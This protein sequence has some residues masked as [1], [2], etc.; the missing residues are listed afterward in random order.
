MG[1][2]SGLGVRARAFSL[3]ELVVVMAVTLILAAIMMPALKGIRDHTERVISANNMR[4]IGFGASMY[5]MDYDALPQSAFIEDAEPE[6]M[7]E[8]MAIYVPSDQEDIRIDDPKTRATLAANGGW[9]GIGLLYRTKYID[10]PRVFYCPAHRGDHPMERYLDD[11]H[12]PTSTHVIYSNYHYRGHED[13]ETGRD[14]RPDFDGRRVMLT[15]GMRTKRDFN[16]RV[17]YN[18]LL[19]DGSVNWR[20]DLSAEI[21]NM[22]PQEGGFG[23]ERTGDSDLYERLWDILDNL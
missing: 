6:L 17:G 9:E 7:Q 15:D 21:Y 12:G 3:T 1:R 10:D 13:S 2:R 23:I 4:Q 8:M 16:H 19:V 5:E 11:L 22:L 14:L 20:Q 18:A